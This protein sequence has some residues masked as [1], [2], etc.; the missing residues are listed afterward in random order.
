[1]PITSHQRSLVVAGAVLF[2]LGLLQG[3]V[4]QIF[5]NPRMGLSAH[6]TAVQ[7]GMAMMIAGALWG[8]ANLPATTSNIGRWT[9]IAG[10]FGLWTAL[11]VSAATGAS[12]NLPIAGAGYSAAKSVEILVTI[13]IGLSSIS[14]TI[15]WL[16]FVAG[17]LRKR[18]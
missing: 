9:I 11:T 7:S 12:D 4:V 8:S 10:M 6:L 16:V 15:G 2:L 13:A 5:L 3:G 17:L 18:G 14:M 1:M